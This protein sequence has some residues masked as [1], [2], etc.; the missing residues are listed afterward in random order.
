MLDHSIR[1]LLKNK[2]LY[3]VFSYLYNFRI[4]YIQNF[5]IVIEVN[6]NLAHF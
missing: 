4:N 2:Y 1:N 5:L 6:K 3:L